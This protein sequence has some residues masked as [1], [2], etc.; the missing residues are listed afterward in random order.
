[1]LWQANKASDAEHISWLG[2]VMSQSKLSSKYGYSAKLQQVAQCVV[3]E[4]TKHYG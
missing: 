1:M 3:Q 2:N 4:E